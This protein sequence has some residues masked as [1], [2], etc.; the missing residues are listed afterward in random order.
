MQDVNVNGVKAYPMVFP[1][2]TNK[3]ILRQ[4]NDI[5]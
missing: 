2:T 1:H 3:E 5:Q 4:R